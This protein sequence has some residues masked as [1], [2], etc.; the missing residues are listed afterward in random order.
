MVAWRSEAVLIAALPPCG[1]QQGDAARK[2]I[3]Q[4]YVSIIFRCFR[5]M[6]QVFSHGCCNSRSRCCICCNVYTH[7][8]QCLYTHVAIVRSKISFC[9]SDYVASVL[10]GCCICLTHILQVFYLDV[11]YACNDIQV[12]LGILQ[13]FQTYFAS[14]SDVC[15]KCFRWMLQK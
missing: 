14:V 8:L 2:R 7:M 3:L 4:A 6:L 13:V 9:F 10:S 5:G 12:F 11:A 1:K 15:C